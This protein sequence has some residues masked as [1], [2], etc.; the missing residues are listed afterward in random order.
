MSHGLSYSALPDSVQ[1]Y[2]FLGD[3]GWICVSRTNDPGRLWEYTGE[4][5]MD[6]VA[7]EIAAKG[8]SVSYTVEPSEQEESHPRIVQNMIEFMSTTLNTN[9]KFAPDLTPPSLP[10]D[11]DLTVLMRKAS[12]GDETWVKDL[13]KRKVDLDATDDAGCTA[14]MHAAYAGQFE[15]VKLLLHAGANPNAQSVQG[16][17]ALTN[18][19]QA[20]ENRTK[21]VGLLLSK[22]ADPNLR[23]SKGK[24]TLDLCHRADQSTAHILRKYRGRRWKELRPWWEAPWFKWPVVVVFIGGVTSFLGWML[25][26]YAKY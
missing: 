14:L 10:D 21:I 17:S 26:E 18:A 24:T 3:D 25:F 15:V 8:G 6:L 16:F 9:L 1:W 22:K 4:R 11:E 12:D 13:L 7:N 19:L 2:V 23:T 20:P 5:W